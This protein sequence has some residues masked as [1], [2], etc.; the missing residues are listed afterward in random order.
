MQYSY[1]T[2]VYYSYSTCM[3][4]SYSTFMYYSDRTVGR[5]GGAGVAAPRN[6]RGSG[7]RSPP[8]MQG[9]RGAQPPGKAGGV[10]GPQAPQL[11]RDMTVPKFKNTTHSEG[12]KF[13]GIIS[14]TVVLI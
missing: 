5:A 13:S 1:S 11:G 4:Y 14:V 12:T 6:C 9:V 3:H 2:C 10:G 7:G 8:E